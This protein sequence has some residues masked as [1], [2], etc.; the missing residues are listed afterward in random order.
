MMTAPHGNPNLYITSD[1]VLG[2]VGPLHCDES[3]NVM[4][5]PMFHKVDTFEID[6]KGKLHQKLVYTAM[7]LFGQYLETPPIHVS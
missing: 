5:F 2:I 3:A 6:R 7:S 4:K 1:N